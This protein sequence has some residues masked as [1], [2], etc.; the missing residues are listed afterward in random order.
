MHRALSFYDINKVPEAEEVFV[1]GDEVKIMNM[2]FDVG[3][4]IKRPI[5]QQYCLHRAMT[6]NQ[7]VEGWRFVGT[8]RKDEEWLRSEYCTREN[9]LEVVGAKD[10]H[11]LKDLIVLDKRPNFTQMIVDHMQGEPDSVNIKYVQ[12]EAENEE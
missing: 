7:V 3:F 5:E 6:N 1:S 12:G 4:D 10:F 9:K 8:E 11:L 2:L